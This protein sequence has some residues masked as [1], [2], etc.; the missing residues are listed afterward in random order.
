MGFSVLVNRLLY[1]HVPLFTGAIHRNMLFPIPFRMVHTSKAIAVN[2]LLIVIAAVSSLKR[3]KTCDVKTL[4]R[5]YQST[6]DYYVMLFSYSIYIN[7]I[8]FI[9]L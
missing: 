8:I 6:N 2:S 5:I 9:G 3:V 1:K 4:P 7:N